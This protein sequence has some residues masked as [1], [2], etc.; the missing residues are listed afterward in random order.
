MLA[1]TSPLLRT[2]KS[3]CL[4]SSHRRSICSSTQVDRDADVDRSSLPIHPVQPRIFSLQDSFY[5]RPLPSH[6]ISFSSPA[7]KTLFRE[8]MEAGDME[9][10]WTLA[11]QFNTQTEPAYCGLTTLSMV[12]N[13]LS[14]DPKRLWK[15]PWRWFSEDLLD[16]C[17]PLE[18]IKK[19]GITFDQFENLAICNGAEI[20]SFKSPTFD[21]DFFRQ[22]VREACKKGDA[23][24]VASFSR[25]ILGQTGDGHF[26]TIAGYHEAKDMVLMMDTAKFKYPAFWCHLPLLR[27]A[28]VPVDKLTSQPRGFFILKKTRRL[29]H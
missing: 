4:A 29:C 23:H 22:K 15:G 3:N 12:L 6:L 28:M 1:T 27:E 13:A 16:C 9:A 5:K 7:G 26:S 24:L 25:G 20:T 19:H 21:E 8:A 10:Y 11:E 17:Y 2:I 14:I 18:E